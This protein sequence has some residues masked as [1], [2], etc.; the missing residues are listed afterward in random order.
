MNF[1]L[2]EQTLSVVEELGRWAAS[3]PLYDATTDDDQQGWKQLVEFGLFD[4]ESE[5]GT[6]LDLA[7][8]VMAAA[9]TPLPGPVVEAQLALAATA[10]LPVGERIRTALTAGEFV[11]SV[12]AGSAGPT[13]VGWGAAA[14]LI[15]DQTDG[16]LAAEGPLPRVEN[17]FDFPHGW[18]ERPTA[19]ERTDD[20]RARRWLLSAAASAGLAGGALDAAVRHVK[21]RVVF[22]RTLS[23]FQA[24]QI[25][26]S[27][28]LIQL[29]AAEWM[30]R[31]AAWRLAEGKPHAAV[32]AA[33]AWTYTAP[34]VTTVC[35]HAHQVFGALGFA[36]ETGLF[37]FTSQARW[38]RLASPMREARDE[39]SARRGRAIGTPPSL[40][41][42]GFTS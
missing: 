18:W 16:S 14:S 22:G 36:T 11:S 27:E 9:R 13:M 26:L 32:S 23:S 15:V 2:P 17:A 33:L 29:D 30:I 28:A 6:L 7:C 10:D 5:G 42:A 1:T 35:A 41:L 24:V 21:D 4:L 40:T 37:R 39:I 34:T 19:T 20:L 8:G 12:P 3:R 31:D 25:R 38:L